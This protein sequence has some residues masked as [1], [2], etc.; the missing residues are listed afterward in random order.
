[1]TISE[2]KVKRLTDAFLNAYN[3]GDAARAASF[4]AENAVYMP[5]H[6][7]AVVGRTEIESF[8]GRMMAQLAPKFSLTREETIESGRLIVQ[9][10]RYTVSLKQG[11]G[12]VTE[13][14]GK[15]VIVCQE[16]YEGGLEI[17]WDIDN[18]DSPSP[19]A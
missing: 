5:S 2:E 3:A 11:D 15:Y 6:H 10:G 16:S 13:D 19:E 17:L 9:R 7:P 8:H 1:M 12:G 14:A 4:Y 18:T